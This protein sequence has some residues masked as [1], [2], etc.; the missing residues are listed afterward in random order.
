MKP[1]IGRI[2]IVKL[3]ESHAIEINRRRTTGVKIA[4]RIKTESWPLGAQAHIGNEVHV[5]D[6]FPAIV[7]R[8]WSD[9][10]VNLQIFLDSNDVYWGTSFCQGDALGMWNWPART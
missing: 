7:V 4:E 8:V 9:T 1:T 6:E 3:G 10:C 2:V 5:G